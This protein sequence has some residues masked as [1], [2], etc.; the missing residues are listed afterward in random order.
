M[1]T[2]VKL[3]VMERAQDDWLIQSIGRAIR[4]SLQTVIHEPL[5]NQMALLLL[6]LA[7]AE[8]VSPCN[9]EAWKGRI[10]GLMEEPETELEKAARHIAKA[11]LIVAEQ[12]ERIA[13]LQAQHRPTGVALQMLD[14]FIKTLAALKYHQRLLRDG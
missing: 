12:R 11:E 4:Q 10:S 5:P 6:Q 7:L 3:R 9:D 8:G 1:T 14:T 2:V 13:Q